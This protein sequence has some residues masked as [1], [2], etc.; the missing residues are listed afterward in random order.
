MTRPATLAPRAA[1]RALPL[2]LPQVLSLSMALLLAGCGAGMGG[3]GTGDSP[4]PGL[5][6]F[7]ASAAPVCDS[8]LAPLLGCSGAASAGGATSQW[9]DSATGG[10]VLLRLEGNAAALRDDCAARRFDG[11][12]GRTPAGQARYY[13]ST[14]ADGAV[15]REGA[16]LALAPA[17]P[18]GLQ[19]Q[20][21]A[22]DGQS[23]GAA[24]AL[25]RARSD[26]PAPAPCPP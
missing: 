1:R 26:D 11:D 8:A 6:A 16:S 25:R 3:T 10:R 5:D 18:D 12:W 22:A 20:L 2:A 7:G 24:L 19:V 4:V 13:G 23:L 15:Q 21:F 9:V 14:L 17:G